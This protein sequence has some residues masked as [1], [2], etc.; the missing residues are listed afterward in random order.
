MEYAARLNVITSWVYLASGGTTKGIALIL[1]IIVHLL[2]I[3][4]VINSSP[5]GKDVVGRYGAK[6]VQDRELIVVFSPLITKPTHK[7]ID[8]CCQWPDSERYPQ[9]VAD[10]SQLVA[11]NKLNDVEIDNQA[12]QQELFEAVAAGRAEVYRRYLQQTKQQ[13]EK[14]WFSQ[15]KRKPENFKC[16]VKIRQNSIGEVIK[17]DFGDC[18]S[19]AQLIQ[20]LFASIQSA[21]PLPLPPESMRESAIDISFDENDHEAHQNVLN[22]TEATIN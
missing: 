6:N 15:L 17:V 11:D 20:S 13:I 18:G 3:G 8:D 4:A 21:S 12:V 14:M 16:L 7:A 10:L 2:V 22:T 1:T 5:S 19:D 9:S